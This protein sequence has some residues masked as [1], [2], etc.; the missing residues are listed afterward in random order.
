MATSIITYEL[1]L[2]QFDD[3]GTDPVQLNLTLN[4]IGVANYICVLFLNPKPIILLVPS[5]SM[6]K[7][8]D[9]IITSPFFLNRG[10]QI[11][12]GNTRASEEKRFCIL[13]RLCD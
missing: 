6:K 4:A 11:L 8:F 5:I 2:I 7:V 10:I 3:Q 13:S 9:I 1:V 12:I